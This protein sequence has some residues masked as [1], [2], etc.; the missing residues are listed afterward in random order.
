MPVLPPRSLA[1]N[2]PVIAAIG[3]ANCNMENTFRRIRCSS[4][5]TGIASQYW[6]EL[7]AYPPGTEASLWLFVNNEWRKRDN[8]S[9]ADR[10]IV[11]KAFL[12]TGQPIGSFMAAL[13]SE[14]GVS[15]TRY[16]CR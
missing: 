6:N 2:R 5:K 11:L 16:D 14:T 8:A 10:S 4:K 12:K 3:K 15:Y 7:V 1:I 13:R 9:P